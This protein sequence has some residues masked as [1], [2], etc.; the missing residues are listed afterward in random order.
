MCQLASL[1]HFV[2]TVANIE[3]AV[4]FYVNVLGM[5]EITFGNNRK[6]IAFGKQKINLHEAGHELQPHARKPL[7]GSADLCFL[8]DTPLPDWQARL[9]AHNVLIIE[10]PIERTGAQFPI[11]SIYIRDLDGNLIEIANKQG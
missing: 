7:P 2:L 4:A 8:T 9:Q 10:G 1:D 3:Q 5:E 6:A 11:I